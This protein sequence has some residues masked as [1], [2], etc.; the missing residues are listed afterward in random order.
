M[1]DGDMGHGFGV[2]PII[3][4]IYIDISLLGTS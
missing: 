3:G 2:Y 4:K 1:Q